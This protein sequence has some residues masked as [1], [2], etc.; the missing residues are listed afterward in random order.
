MTGNI[1]SSY[2]LKTGKKTAI[3]DVEY[4]VDELPD[5]DFA[6]S[7]ARVFDKIDKGNDGILPSPIFFDFIET[8]GEDL[9]VRIW[10][11]IYIN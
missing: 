10:R 5:S 1:L 2:N 4:E 6:K 3:D 7:P 9:I 11:I 8:L